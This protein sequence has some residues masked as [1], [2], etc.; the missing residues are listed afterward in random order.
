MAMAIGVLGM[1]M[2]SSGIWQGTV[3]LADKQCGSVLFCSSVSV[4]IEEKHCV[5]MY[6]YA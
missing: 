2:R 3:I 6:M 1:Q 5:V 4:D